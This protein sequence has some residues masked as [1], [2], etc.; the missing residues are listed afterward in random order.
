MKP[1]LDR[2]KSEVSMGR[3][4]LKICVSLVE[5]QL[6]TRHQFRGTSTYLKLDTQ[7]LTQVT[8]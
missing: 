5:H 7:D 3:N 6:G 2:R 8:L 4:A 1:T